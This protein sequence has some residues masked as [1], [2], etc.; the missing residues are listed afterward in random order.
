MSI[1]ISIVCPI[2]S[3]IDSLNSLNIKTK[4]IDSHILSQLEVV[5]INDNSPHFSDSDLEEIINQLSSYLNVKNIVLKNNKGPGYV[6][7][8]GIKV[9]KTQKYI[10]FL[11]DDDDPDIENIINSSINLNSDIIISPIEN[12]KK[13][14]NF[15]KNVYQSNLRLWFLHLIGKLKTVAWNKVYKKNF[16]NERNIYFS[17]F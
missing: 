5:I 6:R 13:N 2:Y 12:N 3:R 15:D 7:N 11:D 1:N 17:E 9:A 4:L 16:L 14:S 8:L 10:A